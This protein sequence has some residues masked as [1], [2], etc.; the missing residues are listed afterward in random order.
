MGL[1]AVY[2]TVESHRG[3]VTLESEP[4]RGATVTLFLPL[5][6]DEDVDTEPVAEV[7]ETDTR[8]SVLLVDDEDMVR[9]VTREMLLLLGYRVT[10][11]SDGLAALR[12][13]RERSASFDLVILDLVMPSI[14]GL[15]LFMAMRE[16]DSNLRVI[17]V[18]GFSLGG[19]AQRILDEGAKAFLQKPYR[20]DELARTVAGVLAAHRPEVDRG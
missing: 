11:C 6:M 14:G 7:D 17:L 4:G 18:S 12:M 9:E 3:A 2:G 10:D 1:A 13:F 8:A 5:S 15:D 20:A 16:I 19:D